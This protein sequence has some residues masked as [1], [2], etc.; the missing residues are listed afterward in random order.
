MG[1]WIKVDTKLFDHQKTF[2][3]GKRLGMREH[4]EHYA[5]LHIQA[6]WIWAL[7]YYPSGV[8]P[9]DLENGDSDLIAR[10][11]RWYGDSFTFVQSLVDVGFVDED[12]DG[13]LRIHDWE[14]WAGALLRSRAASVERMKKWRKGKSQNA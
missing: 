5:A 4:E 14:E 2:R 11:C 1:A 8:L 12:A 13:T 6:L 10:K 7:D 3:L 9:N